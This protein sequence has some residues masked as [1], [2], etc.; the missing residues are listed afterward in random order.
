M[1]YSVPTLSIASLAMV[2]LAGTAIPVILFLILRERYEADRAPF[3]VGCGVFVVFALL[4]EGLTNSPI[5]KSSAGK[6]IQSNIWLGGVFGGLMAGVFAETGRFI[7]FKTLLRNNRNNDRNALMYGAGQGGFEAFYVLAFGM[8]SNIVMSGMLNAGMA[9]KLAAGITDEAQ[10]AAHC[11]SFATLTGTSPMGFLLIS[12]VERSAAVALHLSLSVLVWFAAKNGG[13][14]TWFYPL[15]LLL[16]TTVNSAAA[17]LSRQVASV[18]AVL[19]V[20]YLLSACCVVIARSVWNKYASKRCTVVMISAS[21]A[22]L[23]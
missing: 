19:A 10:L 1:D 16:H 12:I 18:W 9:D 20:I 7:A 3:F 11:A 13:K 2:S 14:C 17:I 8:I 6:A 21:G 15:A 4:L 23:N 5:F 22:L